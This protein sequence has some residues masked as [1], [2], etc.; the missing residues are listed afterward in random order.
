MHDSLNLIAMNKLKVGTNIY[1]KIFPR[2][3]SGMCAI[4]LDE[5]IPEE[6]IFSIKKINDKNDIEMLHFGLETAMRADNIEPWIISLD[7]L[8]LK[9]SN[10]YYIFSDNMDDLLIEY[11]KWCHNYNEEVQ[12]LARDSETALK[13]LHALNIIN[14]SKD[15]APEK[16]I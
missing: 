14:E 5:S 2:V 16:W 9:V 12:Q 3:K 13:S 10:Q 15:A 4:D 7:E 1:F 11:T 6:Y 8:S